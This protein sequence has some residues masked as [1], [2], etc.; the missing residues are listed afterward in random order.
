MTLIQIFG[1]PILKSC[2]SISSFFISF[3]KNFSFSIK[4]PLNIAF[5]LFSISL[6]IKSFISSNK[7]INIMVPKI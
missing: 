5:F 1:I 2:C 7:G 3:L 6:K 4:S